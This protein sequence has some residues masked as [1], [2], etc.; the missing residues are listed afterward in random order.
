MSLPVLYS[1]RRCPYA[2]RARLALRYADVPYALREVALRDKPADMLA[3]SPK[4]TVPVLHLPD[5]RVLEQSLDIMQWALKQRDPDGWLG[6][7]P[8]SAINTWIHDNDQ[9]FKPLL[10]RYK[11]AERHPEHTREGWR[12][13]AQAM[14]LAPMEAQLQGH[15]FLLADRIS[16]ADMAIVPFVRQFAQVD[17]DWWGQEAALPALRQWLDTLTGSP[18]FQAVMVKP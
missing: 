13:Q 16:L 4:G 1:F 15:P 14:M 18:L 7:A 8:T 6:A 12:T 11:Y 9:R 10:D 2:I 5:G 3:L 17:P